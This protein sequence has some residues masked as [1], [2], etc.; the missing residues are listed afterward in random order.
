MIYE[1]P[2]MAKMFAAEAHKEPYDGVLPYTYH[3]SMVVDNLLSFGFTD[4]HVIC[5]GWLHDVLEDTNRSYNDV[6][7]LFGPDTADLVYAVTNELGK[8]RKERS[9][10]TYPK[11]KGNYEATALKLADR[12][13]NV[14]YGAMH[15]S[16][17]WRLYY[18]ELPVFEKGIRVPESEDNILKAMWIR[19]HRLLEGDALLIARRPR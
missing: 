8:N 17:M 11:I 4:N 14:E 1:I 2:E 10:K 19:L 6:K 7:R 15:G 13:A 5:A 12:I 18:A 16:E 3:L 9:V